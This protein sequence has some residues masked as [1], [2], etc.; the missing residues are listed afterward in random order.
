MWQ[1]NIKK[2]SMLEASDENNEISGPSSGNN[3]MAFVFLV[4]R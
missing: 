4:T 3:R 2:A 1:Y